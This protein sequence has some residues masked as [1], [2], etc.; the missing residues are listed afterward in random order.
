MPGLDGTGKLFAPIIPILEPHFNLVVMTYPDLDSFNDYVDH[1]LN[2]LPPTPGYSLIA[3]SFSG[4]VAMAV[5]GQR[6]DQI[7]PS[8]LCATF[9]RSPL[10]TMTRM[11]S[12]IPSQ[13]FSIGALNEFCL[14]VYEVK[15][16]DFSETQPLPLNVTEQLDGSLLKH[17][18]EV[19]SRIDVSAVL[20]S[21]NVPVLQLHGIRDRIVSEHD[22]KMIEDYLP[23]VKRIDVDT[24]HLLL[25][26]LP[27]HC[28]ELI[29]KFVKANL[30][31]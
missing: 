6:G 31:Q 20:P 14:D 26:T 8:V 22:A 28:S 4:P 18:I 23:I 2:Q 15:E 12:Y 5:M 27:R 16:E 7:G 30:K 17:R 10:A 1:A 29:Y 24:P 21:I 9:A 3:E 19:M 11:A 13:V 25:Q